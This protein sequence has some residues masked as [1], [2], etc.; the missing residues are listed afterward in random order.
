MPLKGRVYTPAH[1]NKNTVFVMHVLN[2]ATALPFAFGFCAVVVTQ[3]AQM[4]PKTMHA[5]TTAQTFTSFSALVNPEDVSA[6]E[7]DDSPETNPISFS[8]QTL[9]S[10]GFDTP[11]E[12]VADSFQV[13]TPT[14]LQSLSQ[15]DLLNYMLDFRHHHMFDTDFMAKEYALFQDVL[16]WEPFAALDY[17]VSIGH[18]ASSEFFYNFLYTDFMVYQGKSQDVIDYLNRFGP[19]VALLHLVTYANL[20]S[21]ISAQVQRDVLTEYRLGNVDYHGILRAAGWDAQ[22]TQD[23]KISAFLNTVP[24]FVSEP[25]NL[26]TDIVKMNAPSTYPK[27]IEY[28]E[29]GQDR[30]RLYREMRSLPNLDLHFAVDQLMARQATMAFDDQ[31]QVALIAL[32]HGHYEALSFLLDS[33]GDRPTRMR[34]PIN[35]ERAITSAVLAPDYVDVT[36]EWVAENI[37]ALRFNPNSKKFEY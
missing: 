26:V 15:D 29:R 13:L 23:E 17:M 4:Q 35:V 14:E 21:E 11:A 30:Y 27:L 12:S 28:L 20:S 16:N 19:N 1:N 25:Y 6:S 8:Q 32:E 10:V 2:K 7:T 22:L 33:T 5:T 36:L 34:S 9:G 3:V 18:D 24:E 37:D 31:V